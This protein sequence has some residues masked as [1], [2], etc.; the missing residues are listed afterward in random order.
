MVQMGKTPPNKQHTS[1]RTQGLSDSQ[2][3]RLLQHV[4][5]KADAARRRGTTRAIVDELI[6][7]L[8]VNTGMK[9]SELCALN[10]ADLPTDRT[11][12]LI[13]VRDASGSVTRTIDIPPSLAD[14]IHRFVANYR[15]G[16]NPD[17][18][19]I[20]GERGNRLIYMSLYSKLKNIGRKAGIGK[21]HPQMLRATYTVS[22]YDQVRD[23][24]FVQKKLGHAG[25]RTTA[26]YVTTGADPSPSARPAPL[27][28]S[29]HETNDA[30]HDLTS[31]P[32]TTQKTDDPGRT[33]SSAYPC[34]SQACQACGASLPTGAGTTI[35]SGQILCDRCLSEIRAKRHHGR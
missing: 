33:P 14:H 23:L 12:E 24:R 11:D 2:L 22:L 35:D 3:N 25:P 9:P 17:E 19:L 7:L 28:T 6:I 30:P 31:T 8:M 26:M 4:K 1:T 13:K 21:L 10:I 16:A 27:T 20:I 15:D 32:R 34:P 29:C 18:P 5:T